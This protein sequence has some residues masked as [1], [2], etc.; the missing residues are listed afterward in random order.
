ME[1]RIEGTAMFQAEIK[2]ALNEGITL[3]VSLTVGVICST[4]VYTM[5]SLWGLGERGSILWAFP[6]LVIT[7]VVSQI[8]V[9]RG[10]AR[11]RQRGNSPDELSARQKRILAYV[12]SFTLR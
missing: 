5:L 2:K 6:V 7:L 3:W 8:V 11:F 1:Q 10:P 9:A 12:E 4:T